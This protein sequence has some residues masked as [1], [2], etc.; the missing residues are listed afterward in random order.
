MHFERFARIRRRS[1]PAGT[2][3]ALLLCLLAG[4]AAVSC[5]STPK[6]DPVVVSYTPTSTYLAAVKDLDFRRALGEGFALA[7]T[8]AIQDDS[9][10]QRSLQ[11]WI[12]MLPQLAEVPAFGDLAGNASLLA[13]GLS[14]TDYQAELAARRSAVLEALRQL[15]YTQLY[16][17]TSD[18]LAL[19]RAAESLAQL[20][21]RVQTAE[22]V[23][24]LALEPQALRGLGLWRPDLGEQPLHGCLADVTAATR[25][26]NTHLEELDA[27]QRTLE[28]VATEAALLAR[29][30]LEA[31]E[32][33]TLADAA[34]AWRERLRLRIAEVGASQGGF[35]RE[36]PDARQL[37]LAL[38]A[39]VADQALRAGQALRYL[40]RLEEV[41]AFGA[42]EWQAAREQITALAWLVPAGTT[43]A[44]GTPQIESR[45]CRFVHHTASG[46]EFAFVGFFEPED[47]WANPRLRHGSNAASRSGSLA[48][49]VSRT[50]VTVE[51]WERHLAQLAE[52]PR[53]GCHVPYSVDATFAWYPAPEATP[54]T[55]L[56]GPLAADPARLP[57]TT[58]CAEQAAQF[59][60][61][62]GFELPS[63]AF[64]RFV[65]GGNRPL[66]AS[67]SLRAVFDGGSNLAGAELEFP[68]PEG[69][70]LALADGHVRLAEVAAFEPNAQGLYDLV[71]NVWEWCRF[72]PGA[73]A[74]EIAGGSWLNGR[75]TPCADSARI[76]TE[77]GA[78]NLGFRPVWLIP[79]DQLTPY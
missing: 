57:A 17:R 49:Y 55:P 4:L 35:Q 39:S 12:Q 23:L 47:L 21:A 40:D 38:Q 72:E 2:L 36:R 22:A 53:S 58:L 74:A 56:P 20:A 1:V 45:Y 7:N 34:A 67:W 31:R 28:R 14:D 11:S 43:P 41:F 59:C 25:T 37:G 6:A 27:A 16:E 48:V 18:V 44:P 24:D 10:E 13:L 69:Q 64:W 78:P 46:L 33:K 42:A 3:Q 63:L 26:L 75:Y 54:R 32:L 65:C 8:N 79:V 60:R 62:H 51:A 52:V 29:F 77:T 5:K 70:T 19:G 9:S 71:G 15:S 61:V 66:S 73:D 30:E 50:E 68:R 76:P